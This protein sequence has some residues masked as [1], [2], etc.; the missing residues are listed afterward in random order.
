MK[1]FFDITISLL[2]LLLLSPLLLLLALAVWFSEPG[3]VIYRG[4]RV[5]RDGR[6]FSILK[7]RS[8]TLRPLTAKT[9]IT[10][11]YDPRVTPIGRFLRSTKLDE[12]PQLFNVL[13]GDMSL[14]GPR[15]ESPYFVEYYT[16]EQREVL[17][18]PPGIT[19]AAQLVYRHEERLFNGD[20]PEKYY[21]QVVMPA[22]LSIDL[23]YVYHHSFWL[24]LQ[25][26]LLTA[27]ALVRPVSLP[28]LQAATIA[29]AP[30]QK[31]TS[32]RLRAVGIASDQQSTGVE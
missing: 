15:P 17:S 7:F 27:V 10:V 32:P 11:K 24:D 13:K 4:S 28:S 8:M 3:P 21:I 16:D 22:K 18:V 12:L 14:V 1:R 19:G 23:E 31:H 26:L 2:L 6:P 20:D 5:G 9:E 29:V 30:Q 25:I